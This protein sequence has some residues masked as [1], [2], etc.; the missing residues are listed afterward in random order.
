[1][2][3][4]LL[5]L[6]F[7][8]K[9]NHDQFHAWQLKTFYVLY[10]FVLQNVPLHCQRS[11][12]NERTGLINAAN[13][14]LFG[15]LRFQEN[16]SLQPDDAAGRLLIRNVQSAWLKLPVAGSSSQN[17]Y[18]AYVQKVESECVTLKLSSQMCLDL[19][20]TD[21]GDIS[22]DVQFQLNRQPLCQWHAAVDRL[23]PSQVSSLLF[24]QSNPSQVKHEVDLFLHYCNAKPF[25]SV[26]IY[27]LANTNYSRYKLQERRDL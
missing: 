9:Q 27:C 6:F 17:V 5:P 24:P 20:L 26:R 7:S 10:S 1:M 18:E 13:G 22:L 25:F 23:G 21:T 4:V 14:E 8:T 3:V 11:I 2:L 12:I 15:I 19:E 16:E